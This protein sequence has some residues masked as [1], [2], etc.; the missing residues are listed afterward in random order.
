MH[1]Q[2]EQKKGAA[3]KTSFSYYGKSFSFST[4][5]EDK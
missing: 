1:A 3:Q 5:S 2:I 4:N